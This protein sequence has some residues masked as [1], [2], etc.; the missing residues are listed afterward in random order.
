MTATEF[1]SKHPE[2]RDCDDLVAAALEGAEQFA[3][4]D[5]F[6]DRYEL[7]LE[8]KACALLASGKYGQ[9]T[10]EA[11]TS[12]QADYAVL[13]NELRCISAEPETVTYA[14]RAWR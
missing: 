7:A 11:K 8:Y 1:I 13:F 3:D 6:G 4:E 9:I 14:S 10:P 5:E 12:L 2:F